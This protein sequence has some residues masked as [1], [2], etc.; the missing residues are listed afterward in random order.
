MKSLINDSFLFTRNLLLYHFSG[1]LCYHL[2]CGELYGEW[3]SPLRPLPLLYARDSDS[4]AQ[5]SCN[6]WEGV[7]PIMPLFTHLTSVVL[8]HDTH[9]LLVVP[10][11]GVCQ[12]PWVPNRLQSHTFRRREQSG[13]AWLWELPACGA[14]VAL[15]AHKSELSS[16]IFFSK[17]WKSDWA[18]ILS[19][20][21]CFQASVHCLETGDYTHIRNILIV[22]TKIL[23]FYP[24]VQNLGQALENRVHKICVKEKEQRPDLYILAIG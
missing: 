21:L 11:T 2:H 7:L 20:L 18:T 1:V 8:Y 10:Y 16:C 14:Q 23:P 17:T 13:S 5:R 6:L 15:H 12:L 4:L 3:V 24:K 19:P 22:L 9:L